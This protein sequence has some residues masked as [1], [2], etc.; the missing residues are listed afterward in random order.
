MRRQRPA[1]PGGAQR[2]ARTK[3]K[4]TKKT[5]KKKQKKNWKKPPAVRQGAAHA[6][7]RAGRLAREGTG[8]GGGGDEADGDDEGDGGRRVGVVFRGGASAAAPAAAYYYSEEEEEEEEEE[9]QKE[10]LPRAVLKST[11]GAEEETEKSTEKE[12]EFSLGLRLDAGGAALD[13]DLDDLDGLSN[14]GNTARR[15]NPRVAPERVSAGDIA[16]YNKLAALPRP[17]M[18]GDPPRLKGVR[19]GRFRLDLHDYEEWQGDVGAR[20]SALGEKALEHMRKSGESSNSAGVSRLV[21]SIGREAF[22]LTRAIAYDTRSRAAAT[23]AR[24]KLVGVGLM[25]PARNKARQSSREAERSL[26]DDDAGAGAGANASLGLG[27]DDLRD[28]L[29]DGPA[30]KDPDEDLLSS[31]DEGAQIH[32]VKGLDTRGLYVEAGKGAEATGGGAADDE[33]DS[34]EDWDTSEW[35]KEDVESAC[36]ALLD[37]IET[38]TVPKRHRMAT[39]MLVKLVL[40]H[41]TAVD[42]LDGGM[43]SLLD[44]GLRMQHNGITLASRNL[45]LVLSKVAAVHSLAER[46][47]AMSAVVKCI[48]C[49]NAVLDLAV[50]EQQ[51]ECIVCLCVCVCV[52][53]SSLPDQM[54][55]SS[56]SSTSF[57]ILTFSFPFASCF[58]PKNTSTHLHTSAHNAVLTGLCRAAAFPLPPLPKRP[59]QVTDTTGAP[60]Q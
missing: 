38:A 47:S 58:Q 36:M 24:E 9:E 1:G 53:V 43:E 46:M 2:A 7:A 28:D 35:G 16:A 23:R 42:Y 17:A 12:T 22:E 34:D 30:A 41:D 18:P 21:Q 5:K 52:R 11:M 27:D 39:M 44:K 3:K 31:E 26:L 49:T 19:V 55:S 15:R 57:V 6:E 14:A 29:L 59:R 20:V 25:K 54:S 33:L 51:S 50:R 48:K 37:E 32:M 10:A 56:S 45:T 8:G 40:K 13:D 4:K 60:A